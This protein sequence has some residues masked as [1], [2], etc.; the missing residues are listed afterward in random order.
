MPVA[1]DSRHVKLEKPF[2]HTHTMC[3]GKKGRLS[4]LP[5]SSDCPALLIVSKD[6]PI[7]IGPRASD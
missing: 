5:H 2:S 6:I 4:R 3:C 1:L 7:A